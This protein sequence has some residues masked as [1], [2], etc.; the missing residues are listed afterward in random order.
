MDA[1]N[2]VFYAKQQRANGFRL[3]AENLP[4]IAKIPPGGR[5][6]D[7]G[8]GTGDVTKLLTYCI[9]LNDSSLYQMQLELLIAVSLLAHQIHINVK[10]CEIFIHIY[11]SIYKNFTWKIL[12]NQNFKYENF[13]NA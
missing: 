13:L 11:I 7:I 5:A 3:F 1:E 4:H 9:S 12:L 10:K 6:L 8:C 2:Y